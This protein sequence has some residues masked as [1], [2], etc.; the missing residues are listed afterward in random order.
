MNKIINETLI[1]SIKKKKYYN[2][3]I[4]PKSE[5]KK[6]IKKTDNKR[7]IKII[8]TLNISPLTLSFEPDEK[9]NTNNL[10]NNKE[11]ISKKKSVF[12]AKLGNSYKYIRKGKIKFIKH[13][14]SFSKASTNNTFEYNKEKKTFKL[15][16]GNQENDKNNL[17]VEHKK[18]DFSNPI[19]YPLNKNKK[20][21]LKNK[22]HM[23][24]DT[25]QKYKTIFT[26]YN[27]NK[28]KNIL[29]EP[30]YYLEKFSSKYNNN[31]KNKNEEIK[32][33]ERNNLFGN[34]ALNKAEFYKYDSIYERNKYFKTE[35]ST[36]IIIQHIL[37]VK[38]LKII[39]ISLKIKKLI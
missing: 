35:S 24:L 20:A 31:N 9:N 6:N 7:K 34:E 32:Y 26:K 25:P 2:I 28:N 18:I 29:E 8:Q 21:K 19:N 36:N 27:N 3:F 4:K 15:I 12:S 22:S 37:K 5:N 16:I 1:N 13:K 38:I 10:F 30:N 14:L 23:N 39:L 33:I 11:N 17:I